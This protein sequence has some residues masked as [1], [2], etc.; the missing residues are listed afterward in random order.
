MNKFIISTHLG[1]IKHVR[2]YNDTSIIKV[3]LDD[4]IFNGSLL[5]NEDKVD[6]N[7]FLNVKNKIYVDCKIKEPRKTKNGYSSVLTSDKGL[8]KYTKEDY[9][10]FRDKFVCEGFYDFDTKNLIIDGCNVTK[11]KNIL[12][13]N[14]TSKLNNVIIDTEFIEDI[15]EKGLFIIKKEGV[16]VEEKPP[17]DSYEEYLLD[18]KETNG[19]I[20]LAEKSYAVIFDENK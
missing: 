17:K 19:K 4:L 1:L 16:Y 8:F 6:L 10:S 9:L 14:E 20:Y 12:E 2:S 5:I 18:I 11:P 15:V 7:T 3:Y 13:F